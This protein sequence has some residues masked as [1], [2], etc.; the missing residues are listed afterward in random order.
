MILGFV[1][2]GIFLLYVMI[3]IMRDELQ[4]TAMWN[5]R[6]DREKERLTKRWPNHFKAKDIEELEAK[7]EYMELNPENKE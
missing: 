5:S 2:V 4:R 7:F 3:R 1:S 6:V